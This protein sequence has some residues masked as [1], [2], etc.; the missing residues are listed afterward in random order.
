MELNYCIFS[1]EY[2]IFNK[3]LSVS[4]F[5]PYSFRFSFLLLFFIFVHFSSFFFHFFSF[6]LLF[7]L[8]FL[9]TITYYYYLFFNLIPLR[10]RFLLILL[11]IVITLKYLLT[12]IIYTSYRVIKTIRFPNH[13][14]T[15]IFFD[16]FS[17]QIEFIYSK[18]F[19]HA[20]EKSSRTHIHVV[21]LSFCST[22]TY[23]SKLNQLFSL[24]S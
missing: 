20:Q 19:A 11:L 5:L 21:L 13:I 22:W 18:H 9:L 6:F 4:L 7:F 15:T 16:R 8:L 12:D 24:F 14:L 23:N 2:S 1:T 10:G 3:L 17:I